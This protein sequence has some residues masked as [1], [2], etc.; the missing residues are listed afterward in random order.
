MAEFGDEGGHAGVD[1]CAVERNLTRGG[2]EQVLAAQHVGDAHECVVDGVHEGVQRVAVGA[3][4]HV[5]G[6][7]ASL[8][9]DFTTDQVVEGD[10][11]VGHAQ[12]PHGLAALGAVG[13]L[14]LFGEV[15]VVVVVAE[16]RVL[17][18]CLAALLHLV[19]GGE[20]FVHVAALNEL[21]E[22][23]VVDACGLTLGLAVGLVGAADADAF[24][25]VDAEPVQGFEHLVERLFGV[26]CRVGVFDAED[27]L[28][29]G[30]ACVGPVEE[31][32]ADHAH[33]RG[34]GGRGAE[35]HA[36]VCGAVEYGTVV[37]GHD[38]SLTVCF[39]MYVTF[40]VRAA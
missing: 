26:A 28:A 8:E 25:P 31:G 38:V 5:V 27:Q 19:G 6:H 35:A 2:G 24:V 10:V 37:F 13:F 1:E 15:T 4:N 7:G 14:L 20:V 18:G 40:W 39:R 11:L 21:L 34:A 33:V 12:T 16:L 3:H 29:A 17:T 22:N 32:G 30:V 36:G 23:L 9:G